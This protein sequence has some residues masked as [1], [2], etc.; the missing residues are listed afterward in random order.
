MEASFLTGFGIF[1]LLG[2]PNAAVV[3]E[4]FGHQSELRLLVAVYGN[5][6]GVNL[7][8][9]GVGKESALAIAGNGGRGV[10]T[11]GVG[12]EEVSVAV[13]AGTDHDS[14][15]SEAFEST[16]H[17]VAGDDTAGTSVNEDYIQHFVAGVE[18]YGASMYLAHQ[19][20]VGTEEQLLTCLTFGVESTAHL[21]TTERTVGQHAAVFASK[22]YALC[23]ALVDDVVAHFGQTI[24]VGFTST[25]VATLHGVVEK[26]IYGVAVVLVVLCSVDTSLCRDG[27]GTAGRVLDAEVLHL[28]AHLTERGGCR[29]TCQTCTHDD[30]IKFTLV[31][32]VHQLLVSFIVGPL[33]SNGTFGNARIKGCHNGNFDLEVKLSLHK[34]HHKPD[35]RRGRQTGT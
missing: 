19:R 6:G 31:F 29:S 34:Q 2:H 11:H 33:L 27:V 23:H 4:R 21:C 20:R 35:R 1:E 30:D 5:A 3:A 22:G 15:C 8:V 28:E 25:I 14:V 12:R 10:A 9:R 16:G 26:T 24:D 17:E 18:F 32:G 7:Y 13:S